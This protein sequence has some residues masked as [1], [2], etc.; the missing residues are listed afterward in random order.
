MVDTIIAECTYQIALPD[1]IVGDNG[2]ILIEIRH[3]GLQRDFIKVQIITQAWAEQYGV[4]H[5][6]ISFQN[7]YWVN[8]LLNIVYGVDSWICVTQRKSELQL[9]LTINHICRSCLKTWCEVVNRLHTFQPVC[10]ERQA[11]IDVI[12]EPP[13]TLGVVNKQDSFRRTEIL[14]V[15]RSPGIIRITYSQEL[16]ECENKAITV[17]E[18]P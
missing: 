4:I 10:E 15:C 3:T 12:E 2:M 6:W 8:L 16:I 5:V 11:G 17:T 13:Q 9:L 1:V 18:S 7:D 14:I